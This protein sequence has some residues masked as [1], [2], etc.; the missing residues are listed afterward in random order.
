MQRITL[1]ISA[2]SFC[3]VSF[4]PAIGAQVPPVAAGAVAG[5]TTPAPPSLDGSPPSASP[6]ATEDTANSE[7]WLHRYR[8]QAGLGELG[9]FLGAV[10]ISDKGNFRNGPSYY[11]GVA[12]EDVPYATFK[13][14]SAE[15]GVRGG[16]YPW[17]FFGAEL[18]GMLA[19]AQS[20]LE[21]AVTILGG[22]A[23]AVVQLPSWSVVPFVAGGIGYWNILND[24]SG[25][26]SAPAFHFGIGAKANVT[27]K[28]ALRLDLRDSITKQRE[29]DSQPHN[30]EL[31]AGAGLVFGREGHEEPEGL[32]GDHDGVPDDRDACPLEFSQL[33]NGCPARD[34][35]QDGVLDAADQCP[36]EAGIAPTGCPVRDADQ[37][38]VIDELDRCVNER[39][40]A[41]TGCPDADEDGF[42]DSADKCPNAA[43]VAPDGCPAD[44]DGDGVVGAADRC[45]LQRETLNGFEDTDGCPDTLPADITGFM[46]VVAGLEFERKKA[47]LSP[48]SEQVLERAATL[49]K[50]Y[51]GLRV[52]IVGHTDSR[53][54]RELNMEL[55]LLRAQAVKDNLALRGVDPDRLV[56]R[57][58]GPDEPISENETAE[59]R[60][61]NRRIEFH[62]IDP[63]TQSTTAPSP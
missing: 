50:Q 45:P 24:E 61:K 30:F 14:P 47:D 59:G 23:Q 35:D 34:T 25:D 11:P 31:L 1:S 21:E 19:A 17:S 49:L 22:R 53:G 9:V 4:A 26:G 54:A 56:A 2:V 57:G 44:V 10:F 5:A 60:Q 18:E 32:D 36:Q 6:R 15:V 46:G 42:L 48:S 7:S 41:P 55:S 13:Q 8:P 3:A 27:H 33:P 51:P 40:V 58:A 39:G 12:P 43:G 29:D 62:L 52:E 16:Y 63:S 28:V 37:D 38:G 20:D